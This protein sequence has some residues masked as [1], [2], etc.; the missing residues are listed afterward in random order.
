MGSSCRLRDTRGP[1]PDSLSH[2]GY[3]GEGLATLAAKCLGGG[4]TALS[5]HGLAVSTDATLWAHYG[6]P[7]R[8]SGGPQ[9]RA[10]NYA[11]RLSPECLSHNAL[12]SED[13][14]SG[15]CVYKPSS[16]PPKGAAVIQLGRPSPAASCT[17]PGSTAGHRVAPLFGL[18][19]SGVWPANMSPCRQC[20]LTAPFHPY[21]PRL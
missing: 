4:A 20:A 9:N 1:C 12:R 5:A 3:S 13:I 17:L 2:V 7:A 21:P 10:Y 15:E 16:V 18:A 11:T 14:S 19:P 8:D 6:W